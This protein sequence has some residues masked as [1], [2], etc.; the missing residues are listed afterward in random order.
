MEL[1][2]RLDALVACGADGEGLAE[3][4]R[5]LGWSRE[6]LKTATEA[7][8]E[9]GE[10]VRRTRE[11][12]LAWWETRARRWAQGARP[13][14]A[15]WGRAM[16]GRFGEDG[17]ARGG[18]AGT[19]PKP[20]EKPRREINDVV[21][22]NMVWAMLAESFPHPWHERLLAVL[23][24]AQAASPAQGPLEGVIAEVLEPVMRRRKE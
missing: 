4:A 19:A 16:A 6:T 10:A 15:L 11:A 5:R 22:A 13:N 24:E 9:L 3:I 20:P 1:A 7:W 18:R 2:E 8:A 21:R 12:A 17:Y 23:A 14:A